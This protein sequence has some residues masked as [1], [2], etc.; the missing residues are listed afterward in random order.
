[1]PK[2]DTLEISKNIEERRLILGKKIEDFL[3]KKLVIV[4]SF[5][6]RVFSAK[7]CAFFGCLTI[8][9]ISVSV[10]S[11]RDIGHDSAAYLEMAKKLMNGGKYCYDFLEFNLPPSL[12][13]TTIPIFLAK[14]F[15][16]SPI[17]SLEIFT[18][19]IG[20]F[21]IYFSARILSRSEIS[22]DRTVFN[23]IILSFACGF[24]LR[25]FTLQFNEFGTKSTYF[26]AL[27]FPYISC[28]LLKES[29]LK[30]RD[31]ILIGTLAALFFCLKPQYGMLAIVFEVKKLIEKKSLRAGFCRRNYITASL[32]ATYLLV[33]AKFF[34]EYLTKIVPLYSDYAK[35]GG[36]IFLMLHRDV[37]PIFI[38]S[39]LNLFLLRRYLFLR[40]FA[41][42]SFAS[43]SI[44]LSE[45]IGGYDQRF[46]FYS[47][48]L[49]LLTL[50]ILTLIR[51]NSIDWKRDG[52]WLFFIL[53]IP[54]FD[55][56]SFFDIL[57]NLSVFWWIFAL[58][59][60]KKYRNQDAVSGSFLNC[61]FLPRD[62]SSWAGFLLVAAL[63]LSL[64]FSKQTWELGWVLST[65]IFVLLIYFYQK[66][67]EEFTC[68]KKLSRLSACAVFAVLSYFFGQHLAV[69]FN[70][71]TNYEAFKYKSPNHVNSEMI[72][73]AKL[74]S[75]V[76]ENVVVIAKWIPDTYPAITYMGKENK[77]PN[78]QFSF[79]ADKK[80]ESSQHI[81]FLLKRQLEGEK[82]KLVFVERNDWC[83]MGWLE[84]F[85][86]DPEFKKIF[87]KNYVFLNRIIDR[88]ILDEEVK[89]FDEG[90]NI[91][92][93]GRPAIIERDVEVYIR[94][95]S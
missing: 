24:F 54:Q 92:W 27:V 84:I 77:L 17:I 20:I 81:L 64:Q 44:I 45:M 72:K 53:L 56:R 15:A 83:E 52:I 55:Q 2:F 86:R 14:F 6:G 61:I 13:L 74:H 59:L 46:I 66:K 9:A 34:P 85:S 18:N 26:L 25:V 95:S 73:T 31:Q 8:L 69:I 78:L 76:G 50:T 75:D 71:E 7:S 57:L 22:K 29:E 41:I 4:V 40:Q 87:Q 16:I 48:S 38:F 1:M 70:L 10:R 39:L 35:G 47:A 79:F 89:F 32:L 28:H 12:L 33:I 36:Q 65:V 63:S 51:S 30:N 80:S 58:F 62:V 68:S 21:S 37:F 60:S 5:F 94:K 23:L 82:A 49:P 11:S 3:L 93:V 67:H 90:N 88:K 19:L 91:K 42:L 43:G